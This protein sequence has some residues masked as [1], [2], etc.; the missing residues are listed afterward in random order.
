MFLYEIQAS[1]IDKEL[2]KVAGSIK[3]PDPNT[4]SL[5]A[6][7][8]ATEQPQGMEEPGLPGIEQQA[9]MNMPDVPVTGASTMD[10]PLEVGKVKRVDPYVVSAVKG[11]SYVSDYR[12]REESKIHPFKII[13][14]PVE[15]L[16][17]LRNL[18]RN[19]ISMSGFE[20][21]Y[22]LYDR[23]DM[24]F[25]QDLISFVE[26]V[27]DLKKTETKEKRKKAQKPAGFQTREESKT[28]AGPVRVKK[29]RS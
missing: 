21:Q 13:Q 4:T 11:T 7:D 8:I 25:Y 15:E 2:D 9:G 17:Q 24:K 12:H 19:R 29:T 22:G 3:N 6:A 5:K 27:Y 1:A 20:D 14:L 10:E 28:K 26:K 16:S 23:P 18:V